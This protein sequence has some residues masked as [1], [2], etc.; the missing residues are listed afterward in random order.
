[1][2]L[3]EKTIRGLTWSGIAQ[4][5]KQLSQFI[6]TAILARMLTP[7]DFGL[8][9]M[10]TV[11]TGFITI[12]A[13]MGISSALIQKQNTKEEHLSSAFWL[14]IFVG[15]LLSLLFSVLAPLIARF[16]NQPQLK[17]ILIVLSL[18][19][20]VASFSIVQQSI[21]TKELEFKTLTK[22]DILAI[23]LSGII[24]ITL[25]ANGFG[26]WSLVLQSLCLTFFNAFLIWNLSTWRP[27]FYFSFKEIKEIF[28]FSSH[29]TGFNVVN[30][31]ARNMDYL[32]I[33][34]FLGGEALG[35][36]SL[37]YKLML[38]PL[39]NI[40]WVISRVMFP[41]FSKIQN[42]LPKI[43]A[44]YLKMVHVI[45]L[46]T[47]PILLGLFAVAPEFV[48]VFYGPKWSAAAQLIQILCFCGMIQSVTSIGG[49]VYLSLGRADL[50][51][52]VALIS[53]SLVS[54]IIFLALPYG[55]MGVALAY[56]VFYAL[57]GHVS[58]L[59]VCHLLKLAPSKLYSRLGGSLLISALTML[60]VLMMKQLL[61]MTSIQ[62]LLLSIVFGILVYFALL[63]FIKRNLFNE[64]KLELHKINIF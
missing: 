20:F 56:T 62:V 7:K 11:F 24:G 59:I 30:Y 41:A 37:A 12:F 49:S 61:N 23:V 17:D 48:K 28:M 40:S 34:K 44:N 18:N 14:N 58:F 51:F 1:M 25:A 3:K 21:L 54:L 46:I 31:F 42:D 64:L 43:R 29:I 63:F 38:A 9:G 33:G 32:L 15:F 2:S 55:V 39:T 16:Y 50:Q 22:R 52:K 36:Y 60:I 26:V 19:F 6:I 47:F 27:R 4:I 45:S 35:L 5:S 53:S 57:W 8:I 13:N 10:A